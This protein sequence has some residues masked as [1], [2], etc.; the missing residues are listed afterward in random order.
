SHKAVA[1]TMPK[2]AIW[3]MARSMKTMPRRS[4]SMPS[5]AC[6][7][8]IRRPATS[9]GPTIDSISALSMRYLLQQGDTVREQAEQ[10]AALPV[11]ADGIRQHDRRRAGFFRQP[12]TCIFRFIGR[13]ED[14]LRRLSLQRLQQ[15]FQMRRSRRNAGF[16]L[17]RRDFL[18]AQPVE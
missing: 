16:R 1:V 5:G 12:L 15:R 10:I 4:T 17:Q 6:V 8:A 3:A 7:A 2:P 14:H 11:S 9:A 18:H 13:A